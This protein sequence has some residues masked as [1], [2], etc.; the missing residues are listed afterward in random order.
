VSGPAP[1]TPAGDP[2]GLRVELGERLADAD[3]P[4][5]AI[6]ILNLDGRHHL[7]PCFETLR[8]LDYPADRHEVILVDNASKDGSVEEMRSRHAWVRLIENRANVG[9]SAG[10]NQ[11]A[12]AAEDA[13]VLVFL[14]NDMR[15]EPS[16]LR[17]LVSPIARGE[18]AATTARMH[19][20]DGKKINSAGGGMNFHGVGIQRGL[21][22]PPGP[23]FEWPR[24]SLF[25]CGGAMAMD[26][27]RFRE[28]GGFDEE[29]FAYY[30]DVDLGWRTWVEGG[31]VWY[32]PDAVCYHHHSSTSRRM[33]RETLRVLQ[34][35]NPLLACF[36]NYDD[37]HLRQLLPAIL[38]LAVRRA[39]IVSGLGYVVD[40]FRIERA[41]PRAAGGLRALWDR[42]RGRLRDKIALPRAGAADLVAI[43]DLLGSWEHWGARRRE[44]QARRGRPDE[45]IFRLF[46]RPE[47]CVED[48]PGYRELQR[49]ISQLYG[50]D[51]L[52]RGLTEPGPEPYK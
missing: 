48:E 23:E 35:R 37:E 42:A 12:R 7:A 19:S 20:W 2:L 16:W 44:V 33:P 41:V 22:E 21:M 18:C 36:K 30:E 6:V 45:E 29:F 26:A 49:G 51:E 8:A 4:R 39:F 32:V 10:C 13:E 34:V 38:A 17:E 40:D 43:N 24:K 52:F 3:L 11:G 14:N 1:G 27:R 31:E 9:F 28:V 50:L 47:W 25:A 46:L 5:C 15:V